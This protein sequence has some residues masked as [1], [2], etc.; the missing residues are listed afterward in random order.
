LAADGIY[1]VQPRNTRGLIVVRQSLRRV[2]LP[3]FMLLLGQT[4]TWAHPGHGVDR[5]GV[6]HYLL[7]PEHA[8]PIA[9]MLAL[10]SLAVAVNVFRGIK[11]NR[12]EWPVSDSAK[13]EG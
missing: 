7:E 9:A 8:M 1:E 6:T 2:I 4:S 11:R 3:F 5:S 10:V 13:S 12:S